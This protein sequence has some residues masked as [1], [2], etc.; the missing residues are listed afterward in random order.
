M[1]V[2]RRLAILALVLVASAL[3][4]ADDDDGERTRFGHDIHVA[5]TDQTGELT[6]FFCSIYVRGQV[7]GD[8][9]AFGGK[10]ILEAPAQVGG[11]VTTIVGDVAVASGTKVGGDV[12]A[13]GGLVERAPEAEIGGDVTP[14]HRAWWLTLLLISPLVVLG[15]LIAALVWFIQYLRRPRTVPAAV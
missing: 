15:V 8:I 2:A 9:T 11:D 4:F 12:T 3:A 13:V 10:V 14:I 7:T 5:A 6:C 1:P